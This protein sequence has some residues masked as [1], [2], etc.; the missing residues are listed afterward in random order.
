MLKPN[1]AR[2]LTGRPDIWSGSSEQEPGLQHDGVTRMIKGTLVVLYQKWHENEPGSGYGMRADAIRMSD[3]PASRS[4]PSGRIA[5][6]RQCR[7]A[8]SWGVRV[9]SEKYPHPRDPAEPGPDEMAPTPD[10][11]ADQPARKQ[12]RDTAALKPRIPTADRK[13]IVSAAWSFLQCSAAK[14]DCAVQL[15]EIGS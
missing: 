9:V 11:V 10:R 5:A 13:P 8:Q 6:Y 14:I 7:R 2:Q 3:S 15:R 12:H 4:A 1:H